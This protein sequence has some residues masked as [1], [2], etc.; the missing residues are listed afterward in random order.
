MLWIMFA[1]ILIGAIIGYKN[2]DLIRTPG[3]NLTF[4]IFW[5]VFVF[6]YFCMWLIN[7]FDS[8]VR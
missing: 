3:Q 7:A 4:A 1:Y 2:E 5:P 8:G 6:L